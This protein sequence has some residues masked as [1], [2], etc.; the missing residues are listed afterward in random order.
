SYLLVTLQRSLHYIEIHLVAGAEHCL[1]E[2]E[3]L[4][5]YIG[6]SIIEEL[7][8]I[9]KSIKKLKCYFYDYDDS[10]K[11]I[12]LIKLIEAQKNLSEVKFY[13]GA[14]KFYKILKILEESLDV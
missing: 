11:I 3:S 2:L 6:H 8:R 7:T 1:S 12:Q 13:H 5:C 4:D 9:C 10:S 14:R